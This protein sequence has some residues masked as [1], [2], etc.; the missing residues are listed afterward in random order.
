MTN[1]LYIFI[2]HLFLLTDNV[3]DLTPVNQV[4][5]DAANK[6]LATIFVILGVGVGWWSIINIIKIAKDRNDSEARANHIQGL[7]WMFGAFISA[8]IIITVVN[9]LIKQLALPQI[10]GN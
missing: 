9:I 10:G 6:I 4:I 3:P 8:P 7:Q 5:I 2:T 1:L